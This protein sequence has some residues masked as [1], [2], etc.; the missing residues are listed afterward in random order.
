MTTGSQIHR[1]SE[2]K[3]VEDVYVTT[4]DLN[5][6]VDIMSRK[7][8][9]TL[10]MRPINKFRGWIPFDLE[11]RLINQTNQMYMSD[12]FREREYFIF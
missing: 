7:D 3:Y 12:Y 5:Y 10:G 11:L 9:M 4:K 2:D 6:D 8:I 1:S